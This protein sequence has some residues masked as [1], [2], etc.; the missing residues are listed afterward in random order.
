MALSYDV[1]VAPSIPTA[2]PDLPPDLDRR[3]WSPIAS[4]LIHGERDAVLVDPLM[5]IAPGG[6]LPSPRL[7]AGCCG[8]T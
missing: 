3:W 4:T 8:G 6:H 5:T 7:R 2:V 1:Y